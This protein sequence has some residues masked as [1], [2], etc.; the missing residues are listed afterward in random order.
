MTQILHDVK[1][2]PFYAAFMVSKKKSHPSK[3]LAFQEFTKREKI[4]IAS[5]NVFGIQLIS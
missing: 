1:P 5:V 3:Y 4:L 2:E